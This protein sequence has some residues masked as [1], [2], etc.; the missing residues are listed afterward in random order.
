MTYVQLSKQKITQFM[1]DNGITKTGLA[2][3][4][5]IQDTVLRNVHNPDWD[6]RAS[7]LMKL[8]QAISNNLNN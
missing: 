2:R 6:P 8:E 5:G 7:T 1:A 3:I 4:A